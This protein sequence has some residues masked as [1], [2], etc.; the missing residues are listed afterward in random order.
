M[1]TLREARQR[2]SIN[3]ARI[4]FNR[5]I[6]EYRVTLNEWPIYASSTEDKAYYTDDIDDA[7]LTS[8][9]M[10]REAAKAIA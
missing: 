7:V 1:M 5:D 4:T 10:R 6:G 3:G 2:A 9:A 8:G